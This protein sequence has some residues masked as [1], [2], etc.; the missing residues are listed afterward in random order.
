MAAKVNNQ[1]SVT[2]SKILQKWIKMQI[3]FPKMEVKNKLS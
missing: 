3:K 2:V 1:N